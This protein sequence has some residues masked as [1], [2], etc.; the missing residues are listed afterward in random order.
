VTLAY[1]G[2]RV[3]P[4]PFVHINVRPDS[5]YGQTPSEYRLEVKV[6]GT[7]VTFVNGDTI[8]RFAYPG[9]TWARLGGQFDRSS[10]STH[11]SPME[12]NV[13][14]YYSGGGGSL[15]T[16]TWSTK[17]VLV[18]EKDTL[19]ARGWTIAGIQRLY[20]QGDASALITE[21][22]GST[23]YFAKVSNVLVRP[24]GEFSQLV[25]GQPGGGAGWT[26]AYADSTKVVFNS[27]GRMI[28]T[29]DRFNNI[30]TIVYD[31]NNRVS[32]V[33][34]PL[35]NAITL[36]YDGNGLTSIQ[37]PWSR[38][39]E[40][41]AVSKR[42]TTIADPDNVST[43]FGYDGSG[44]LSTITNR[45]GH[46]TTLAYDTAS[47]KLATIASPSVTYVG[48]DG[49]D[50]TGLLVKTQV[51]WQK[52]GVPYAATGGSPFT[53]PIADTV[54]A[55]VT[56]PGGHLTRF[57]VNRW[58][59]PAVIT[60]PLGRSDST[61]FDSNGMPIRTRYATGAVDSAVY[62]TMGLP[63]RIRKSGYP[64]VNTRYAAWAQ[65][66]SV[67]REGDSSGVRRSIGANGRV[68][69]V[70]MAGGTS[71]SAVTRY[72]YESRGRPDSVLDAMNHLVQRTWYAG[73]NGNRSKDSTSGTGRVTYSYDTY[74]R[75][76]SVSR[77]GFATDTTFYSII[78]RVDSVRDGFTP[79]AT[80]YGY[81]NMFLTSVTDAKNQVHGFSYNAVGW[82]MQRTDPVSRSDVYKYDR[83]GQ[84][85]RW[86]NRRGYVI[87]FAYDAGHRPTQ[88]SGDTTST[89][90]VAYPSDTVVIATNP[91]SQDT[92]IVN[93]HGQALRISTVIAGQVF[94]RRYVYTSV[95]ALDSI[96]P[97]GG[98]ITFRNRKYVWNSRTGVLK[99]I[100]LGS[101]DTTR[102]VSNPDGQPSTLV[103]PGA[104]TISNFFSA[105]HAEGAVTIGGAA[106]GTAL[107][108]Y[109]NYAV[110]GK[111]S[112][113]IFGSGEEGRRYS[114]DSL[115]RLKSDSF[116]TWQGPPPPC[117]GQRYPE[118]DDNG[119]VCVADSA[120]GG[121]WL[122]ASG[123]AFSY[124]SAGNRRDKGGQY[125]T[126]NRITQFDGCSY[127]TDFDGNVTQRVCGTDTVRFKWSA[128]SRLVSI[129][130][131]GQTIGFHYNGAGELIRKDVSGA[132]HAYFLWDQ[133]NLLA[134]L[135]GSGT[136]KRLEYSYT[137]T[138]VPHATITSSEVLHAHR[139][140]IGNVIG[141]TDS[142][143]TLRGGFDYDAWGGSLGS[144]PDTANRARFKGA[145]WLGPEQDIYFMR[146]RWYETKS[147]RFL[148]EDP[149]GLAGGL[150]QY[151]YAG[152]D[153]I[154]DS[155]PLGLCRDGDEVLSEEVI[156]LD[157]VTATA[158]KCMGADGNVY[159]WLEDITLPP[160]TI[161][162]YG[163]EP[164]W[165]WL[166]VGGGRPRGDMP[167]GG[168]LGAIAAAAPI[169]HVAM[170]IDPSLKFCMQTP[171]TFKSRDVLRLRPVTWYMW[172][173]MVVPD[174][175]GGRG[176]YGGTAVTPGGLE[177]AGGWVICDLALGFFTT[178]P[179][180]P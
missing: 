61:W 83:D 84:R 73:T 124:D 2:D 107:T 6:N 22:D 90:T 97:S 166:S 158:Q 152:D 123:F 21:G 142:S 161:E 111:I 78:N 59:T 95:G 102:I 113:Q 150:N 34:D 70:R 143:V 12:I 100:R 64:A 130:T 119:T 169:P 25:N 114:Y 14:A 55:R 82:L 138:D 156:E 23:I 112:E 87:S 50:S 160:V 115:G 88:K 39:T 27:S 74:G 103:L 51:P 44:R 162:G 18:N 42:I 110:P 53:A 69:W 147:G 85:R 19:V 118:Q 127:Q 24:P 1:H 54:Y 60:D 109:I 76:K 71:D 148:S 7:R 36:S 164:D 159:L 52:S 92:A 65:T 146:A 98:G 104:D 68:D 3:N 77:P 105:G 168:E 8:L 58:G 30:T 94:A 129:I 155:D 167:S 140:G 178:V 9:N 56:D 171:V 62:N 49:S 80:R 154:N 174:V 32:Q 170:V 121:Q 57:T 89:E 20:V 11:V 29:R 26:R 135:A 37:D 116:V 125:A 139:D 101:S 153:P 79:K 173:M 141:L 108:R 91:T 17:L 15:K 163:P 75:M 151:V 38:V 28:E 47:G 45:R 117:A 96:I 172:R 86:I 16:N 120:G 66:D 133:G 179:T 43:T 132:P 4:K 165:G 157:G 46:T 81:D 67:W 72:R 145:L 5:T 93:R 144:G 99:E 35:N 126:G 175:P 177:A 131:G 134:E 48:S 31:G 180:S 149:I 63:T 128:E 137:D 41:V 176:F 106:W 10:D 136:A 40:I 122:T 33:K 13:S